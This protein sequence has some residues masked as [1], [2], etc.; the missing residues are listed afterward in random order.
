MTLFI[1]LRELTARLLVIPKIY[2]HFLPERQS[3]SVF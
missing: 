2:H 1:D 3:K